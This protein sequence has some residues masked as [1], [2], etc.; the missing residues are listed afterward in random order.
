MVFILRF[1]FL[2]LFF[3]F[4]VRRGQ[5]RPCPIRV[6]EGQRPFNH[7]CDV[8]GGIVSLETHY[9]LWNARQGSAPNVVLLTKARWGKLRRQ[10]GL[11]WP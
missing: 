11:R 5:S 9:F 1:A 7:S 3:C 2:L 6:G 4:E 8:S 10:D